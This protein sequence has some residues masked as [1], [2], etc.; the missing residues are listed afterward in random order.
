M[1][2]QKLA[3]IIIIIGHES[4]DIDELVK[5]QQEISSYVIIVT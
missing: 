5:Y 1:R 2:T 3:S 4:R